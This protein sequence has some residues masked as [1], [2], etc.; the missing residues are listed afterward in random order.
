MIVTTS[1]AGQTLDAA[2]LFVEQALSAGG[3]DRAYRYNL[4]AALVFGRS[5][6]FHLQKEFKH[7]PGFEQWYQPW[8]VKMNSDPNCKYFK[9]KRNFVLKEGRIALNHTL[10]AESANFILIGGDLKVQVIRGRPW[11]QRSVRIIWQD[12]IAPFREWHADRNEKRR[13]AALAATLSSSKQRAS[14]SVTGFVD[15]RADESAL[16][17]VGE[18]LTFLETVV[19]DA[20][21]EFA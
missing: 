11:Y 5:V 9:D 2:R 10:F 13:R 21:T 17:V 1:I 4:E 18:Y 3:T 6:T 19:S 15:Y 16:A 20:E 8:Q 14:I 7:C 12:A